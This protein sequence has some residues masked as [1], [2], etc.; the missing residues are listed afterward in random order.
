VCRPP[1]GG[2]RPRGS[3][4][5]PG[6][7]LTR[8]FNPVVL[9]AAGAAV[10][11]TRGVRP[12]GLPAARSAHRVRWRWQRPGERLRAGSGLCRRR[13]SG[14][15]GGG[16]VMGFSGLEGVGFWESG[17]TLSRGSPFLRDSFAAAARL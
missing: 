11:W 15:S 16:G 5:L 6:L 13:E 17:R 2:S 10:L 8:G 3:A 12:T 1:V 14:Y 9:D 7:V 4:S